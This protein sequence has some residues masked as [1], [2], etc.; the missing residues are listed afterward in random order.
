MKAS[1]IIFSNGNK[2]KL[3]IK[4][5]KSVNYWTLDHEKMAEC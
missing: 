1:G 4:K 2:L 3:N 5:T